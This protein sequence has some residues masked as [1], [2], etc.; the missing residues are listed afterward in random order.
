MDCD[1]L[2]IAKLKI[3]QLVVLLVHSYLYPELIVGFYR[4][5]LVVSP[6]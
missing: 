6:W 4:L 2:A 1:K 3:S 5:E